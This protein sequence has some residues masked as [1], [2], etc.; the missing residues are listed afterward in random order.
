MINMEYKNIEKFSRQMILPFIGSQGQNKLQQSH[1]LVVGCGGLGCPLLL[2][3]AA[4]GIGKITLIDNDIICLSNL[5]RQILFS[6]HDIGKYK[7]DVA[8]EKLKFLH[9][10]THII[11]IKK[12]LDTNLAQ[13][14]SSDVDLVIDGTDSFLTKYILSEICPKFLVGAVTGMKGYCAGFTP[15]ITYRDIFPTIPSEAPNCSKSGVLGS[16]AG[17]IGTF[18]ATETIKILL[19]HK[20][21]ILNKMYYFDSDNINK[22][23]IKLT[24]NLNRFYRKLPSFEFVTDVLNVHGTLIDIRE[25]HELT[26]NP[27]T[28]NSLSMPLSKLNIEDIIKIKLPILKCHTGS[29][30]E[31]LALK[32]ALLTDE[33]SCIKILIS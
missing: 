7:V 1:I 18:L 13:E 17:T 14:I 29:R 5:H 19:N 27:L 3:L 12:R 22:G 11:P 8:A 15:K 10:D 31:R 16:V 33:I 23:S 4:S 28:E 6:H 32:I 2:Y 30:A 24:E 25:T 20:N 26:E 21:T 9:P